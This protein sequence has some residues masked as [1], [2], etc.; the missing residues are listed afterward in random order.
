M[1]EENDSMTTGDKD[2]GAFHAVATAAVQTDGRW[3]RTEAAA[4]Y[5]GVSA[6]WLA[7]ARLTGSHAIPF[8]RMGKLIVYDKRD[9]DRWLLGLPVTTPAPA[10]R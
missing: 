10:K 5:L 2:P 3:L 6:S 9:L 1:E 7:H 4:E 8:R